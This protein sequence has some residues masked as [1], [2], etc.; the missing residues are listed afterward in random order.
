MGQDPVRE[1]ARPQDQ[2]IAENER[3]DLAN[4]ISQERAMLA[5]I[6][7]SISDALVVVGTDGTAAEIATPKSVIDALGKASSIQGF[8]DKWMDRMKA[9]MRAWAGRI[10]AW[11]EALVRE[12]AAA[13]PIA[14]RRDGGQT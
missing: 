6:L 4:A 1:P 3:A 5:S 8:R 7:A 13:P 12:I 11:H 14:G 10:D 9:L 2:R